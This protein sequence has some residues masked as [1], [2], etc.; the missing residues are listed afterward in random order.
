MKHMTNPVEKCWP[1]I[2]RYFRVGKNITIKMIEYLLKKN[3]SW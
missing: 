1:K 2:C 3:T